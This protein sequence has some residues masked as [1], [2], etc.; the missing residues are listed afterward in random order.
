[1]PRTRLDLEETYVLVQYL[2]HSADWLDTSALYSVRRT[3]M[4]KSTLTLTQAQK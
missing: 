3:K 4:V 1:M 2:L